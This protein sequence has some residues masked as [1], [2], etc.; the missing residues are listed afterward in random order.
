M[1]ALQHPHTGFMV[2]TWIGAKCK[3]GQT[4]SR[5]LLSLWC[6]D[7]QTSPDRW[8]ALLW[9]GSVTLTAWLWIPAVRNPV[10]WWGQQGVQVRSYWGT[11]TISLP[12]Y[13][14]ISLISLR[15]IFFPHNCIFSSIVV[16]LYF[17]LHGYDWLVYVIP[18]SLFWQIDV[19]IFFLLTTWTYLLE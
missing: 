13:G 5:V 11:D 8:R 12:C 7:A 16:C 14:A 6:T 18:K 19:F 15:R 9:P 10:Q 17:W 3:P 1:P 4:Q 2:A